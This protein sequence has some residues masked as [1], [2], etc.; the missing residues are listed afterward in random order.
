MGGS[1]SVYFSNLG[2]GG[3]MNDLALFFQMIKMLDEHP[4]S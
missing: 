2:P 3:L 1:A 4:S